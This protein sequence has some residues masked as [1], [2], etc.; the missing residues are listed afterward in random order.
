MLALLLSSLIRTNVQSGLVSIDLPAAPCSRLL[1]MLGKSLGM[2]LKAG[3][4]IQDDVLLIHTKD[5]QPEELLKRI[6]HVTNATW[7]Q[8]GDVRKLTKTKEQAEQD[9]QLEF[10]QHLE[11]VRGEFGKYKESTKSMSAF[12]DAAA[13]S[14]LDDC[15]KFDSREASSS[16]KKMG[17][18]AKALKRLISAFPLEKLVEGKTY[19]TRAGA[20]VAP[21]PIDIQDIRDQFERE[22]RTWRS[23]VNRRQLSI[24]ELGNLSKVADYD[25]DS[26]VVRPVMVFTPSFERSIGGSLSLFTPDGKLG[27]DH[28]ESGDDIIRPIEIALKDPSGVGSTGDILSEIADLRVSNKLVEEMVKNRRGSEAIF[29]PERLDPIEVFAAPRWREFAGTEGVNLVA[30][31]SDDYMRGAAGVSSVMISEETQDSLLVEES[32]WLEVSPRYPITRRET[33]FNRQLLGQIMRRRTRDWGLP[34]LEQCA[35]AMQVNR[36]YRLQLLDLLQGLSGNVIADSGNAVCFPWLKIVGCLT[37]KQLTAASTPGGLLLSELTPEQARIFNWVVR[38]PFWRRELPGS[39]SSRLS[40]LSLEIN[41]VYRQSIIRI[42]PEGE[43]LNAVPQGLLPKYWS[44]FP[45]QNE[46]ERRAREEYPGIDLKKWKYD[47]QRNRTYKVEIMLEDKYTLGVSLDDY[48][49]V[50]RDLNYN[51]IPK[52]VRDRS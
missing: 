4:G 8:I 38:E 13:N 32:G 16:F 47:L 14:L 44:C 19:S 18:P 45:P 31:L 23:A 25:V 17:P 24:E 36:P 39:E 35:F 12:D 51:E 22:M 26:Q 9:K 34:L 15:L 48:V 43:S 29:Y 10:Q 6:A 20:L 3:S 42:I 11:L 49:I 41:G 2:N 52:E 33:T 27:F 1:P 21:F 5:V 50:K 40:D 30:S 46:E 37:E 28:A 7:V